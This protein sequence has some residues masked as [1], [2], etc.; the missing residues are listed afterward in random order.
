ML[1][2]DLQSFKKFAADF[3]KKLRPNSVV[4]FNGDLGAGKTEFSRA[5]IQSLVSKDQNIPSPTFTIVQTYPGIS[6]FDLYRVKSAAELEEIGLFDAI[7]HDI[8]L[9]EWPEL[10]LP[11]LPKDTIFINITADGTAREITIESLHGHHKQ[12]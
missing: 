5:I 2:K 9:I 3:A 7:G 6:H 1:L 10:A 12:E 4:A 8:V 11:F